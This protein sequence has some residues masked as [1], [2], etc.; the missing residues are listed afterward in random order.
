MYEVIAQVCFVIAGAVTG[1]TDSYVQTDNQ[2]L[3]NQELTPVYVQRSHYQRYVQRSHYQRDL[4]RFASV[5]SDWKRT[6]NRTKTPSRALSNMHRRHRSVYRQMVDDG[7][8]IREA[9]RRLRQRI[10]S[11][12]RHHNHHHF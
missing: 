11:M 8:R 4:N 3:I 10:A 6:I 1:C 12:R 7:I 9:N 5:V 2:H